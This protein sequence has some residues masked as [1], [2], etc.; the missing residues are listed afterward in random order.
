MIVLAQLSLNTVNVELNASLST[1]YWL[2]HFEMDDLNGTELAYYITP[3]SSN[4]RYYSFEVDTT[5]NPMKTGEWV[6][7]VFERPN[8]DSTDTDGL[9]ASLTA[10]V[11]I[12]KEFPSDY[13][14]TITLT[15]YRLN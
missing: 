11:R 12:Y 8:E 10:K 13:I 4:E 2:F 9:T 3:T 1:S 7:K 6:L 5:A 15:D 14:N